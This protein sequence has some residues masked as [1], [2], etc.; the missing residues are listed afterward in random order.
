M[1][2]HKME[3]WGILVPTEIDD[4]KVPVSYHSQWDAKV[5]KI[6]NGLTVMTP[7]K[8]CWVNPEFKQTTIRERM[9]PVMIMATAE[10]MEVISDITAEHYRQMAIMYYRMSD[11]VHIRH[12]KRKEDEC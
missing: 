12:Y 9:I 11:Q 2:Q 5:I 4:Q 10:Q 8:G 7:V 3:I 6:T 1:S